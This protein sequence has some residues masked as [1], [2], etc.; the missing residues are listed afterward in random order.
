MAKDQINGYLETI[1]R[2]EPKIHMTDPGAYGTSIAISLKRIGDSLEQ[3]DKQLKIL[4][5][6]LTRFTPDTNI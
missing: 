5:Q 1:S 6:R 4:T 2:F 3:I